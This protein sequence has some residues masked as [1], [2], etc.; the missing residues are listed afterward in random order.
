MIKT[1]NYIVSPNNRPKVNHARCQD[2]LK[3]VDLHFLKLL[4][5]AT[6]EIQFDSTFR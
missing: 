5:G 1:Q 4:K 6:W 2:A 3:G